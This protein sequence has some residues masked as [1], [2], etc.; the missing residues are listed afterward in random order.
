MILSLFNSSTFQTSPPHFF[1][2]PHRNA[3][4]TGTTLLRMRTRPKQTLFLF[5][6]SKTE[7]YQIHKEVFK[8]KEQ[9]NKKH[10]ERWRSQLM[11]DHL[12]KEA[13]FYQPAE[14]C[15]MTL[16]EI[17]DAFALQN[18]GDCYGVFAVGTS[19]VSGGYMIWAGRNGTL[20]HKQIWIFVGKNQLRLR[21]AILPN[22]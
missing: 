17:P 5:L 8:K 20:L 9:I 3:L 22:L 14:M 1:Q 11:L 15:F 10:E 13:W 21:S 4:G 6:S 7:K 2:G 12:K 16:T 19:R 18:E